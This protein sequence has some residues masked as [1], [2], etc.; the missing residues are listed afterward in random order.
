MASDAF[1]PILN[2]ISKCFPQL[3]F[4]SKCQCSIGFLILYF[5]TDSNDSNLNV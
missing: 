2:H 4:T 1:H 5:M 3:I